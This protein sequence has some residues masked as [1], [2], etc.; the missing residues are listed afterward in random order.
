MREVRLQGALL[1]AMVGAMWAEE[2]VDQFVFHGRL[3]SFG[4]H[5]REPR[6]LLGILTAPFLHANFAHLA[7]N[8]IPL[9]VLGLF[10]MARR[11]R[12]LGYVFALSALVAGVG[13]WVFGGGGTVHLGASTVVFGF[14]GYLLALGVFERS[15]WT[16]AGSVVVF[17]LYG[18]ALWGVLPGVPGISWEGHLFGLLGGVLAARVLARRS[19]RRS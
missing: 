14:L 6:G 15:F 7:A 1:G 5:P 2:L 19:V 13:T 4:I 8:S 17:F 18:G 9:L 12:D 10:V 16:I 3:N 11:K